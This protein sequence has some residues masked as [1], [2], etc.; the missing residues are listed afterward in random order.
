MDEGIANCIQQLL[1]HVRTGPELFRLCAWPGFHMGGNSIRTRG[2]GA[3]ILRD[4]VLRLAG[5]ARFVVRFV[6]WR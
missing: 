5:Y 6:A 1:R 3:Q 2:K 4:T